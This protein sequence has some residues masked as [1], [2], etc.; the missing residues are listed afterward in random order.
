MT[1]NINALRCKGQSLQEIQLHWKLLC[2]RGVWKG[3]NDLWPKVWSDWKNTPQHMHVLQDGPQWKH[4]GNKS[5]W[6]VCVC[7]FACMCVI[8][9]LHQC[10]PSIIYKGVE[11]R[12]S[13]K[14]NSLKWVCFWVYGIMRQPA[15]TSHISNTAVV[16]LFSSCRHLRR[17]AGRNMEKK[18]LAELW[19][20]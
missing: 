20:I 1:L 18:L 17:Q 8:L 13:L 11:A 4:F 6:T 10:I 12:Q 14:E 16:G 2:F 9:Y 7:V 5:F 15:T 3:A 19:E